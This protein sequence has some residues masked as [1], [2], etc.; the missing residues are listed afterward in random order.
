MTPAKSRKLRLRTRLRELARFAQ[1]IADFTLDGELDDAGVPSGWTPAD[2]DRELQA[3]TVQARRLLHLPM[4]LDA[5]L[6]ALGFHWME[7]GDGTAYVRQDDDGEIQEF[8]GL[9][10][11]QRIA[12]KA[13][14]DRVTLATHHDHVG[15]EDATNVPLYALLEALEGCSCYALSGLRWAN[16]AQPDTHDSTCKRWR[17]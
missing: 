8:I 17:G 11:D 1:R 3:L 6:V 4:S 10:D 12:P 9:A 14:S 16:R 2:R 5:R 7:T 15:E 13:E